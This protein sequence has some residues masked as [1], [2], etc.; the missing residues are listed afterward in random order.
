MTD[1]VSDKGYRGNKGSMECDQLALKLMQDNYENG[2]IVLSRL[3]S[4]ECTMDRNRYDIVIVS[5]DEDRDEMSY[6]YCIFS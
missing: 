1:W 2:R 5:G 3:N 4:F 6:G